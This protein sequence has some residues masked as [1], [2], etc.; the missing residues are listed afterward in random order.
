M[1]HAKSPELADLAR[2]AMQDLRTA[3][4]ALDSQP[5]LLGHALADWRAEASARCE[6]AN[7]TLHWH[8]P[9]P[10]LDVMLTARQKAVMERCLRES[11]T[12][13]LKHGGPKQIDIQATLVAEV[14]TLQIGHDGPRTTPSAWTEGR[15]LR[16]MK[17]RLQEVHGAM[18]LTPRS[19][20]GTQTVLQL[21]LGAAD[22]HG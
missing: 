7:V 6:A 18:T 20:G 9:S 15:G 16:G 8:A 2:A 1:H 21:P 13:A 4:A 19:D 14:L 10:D 12:N 11:L 17:H 5:V 22:F 3:L